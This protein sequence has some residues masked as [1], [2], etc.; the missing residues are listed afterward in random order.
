[1]LKRW[2]LT[3]HPY[4]NDSRLTVVTKI[5]CEEENTSDRSPEPV[6]PDPIAASS[7]STM[8]SSLER[9]LE[10]AA[11][12]SDGLSD[13][14]RR[15][16]QVKNTIWGQRKSFNGTSSTSFPVV[17]ETSSGTDSEEQTAIV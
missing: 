6:T 17:T 13:K 15:V 4:E 10:L 11:I 9:S 16:R 7:G 8:A 1:M 5:P 3:V 14:E 2:R 12:H